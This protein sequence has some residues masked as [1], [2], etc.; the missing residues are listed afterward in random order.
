MMLC[1]L[2][3]LCFGG[4]MAYRLYANHSFVQAYNEEDYETEREEKLLFL[5]FPQGYIPHYNLGNAAYRQ[6]DYNQAVARYNSALAQHPTGDKDCQIRINLALSLCNTIDF[7]SL[8]SQQKV[9]NALFV[10]YKARDVLLENGCATEDGDGH[11]ADAQQLKEDIDRMIEMLKNPDQNNSG[12]DQSNNDPNQ[13]DGS[14]GSG[15]NPSDREKRIQDELEENRKGALEDR[16][17]QQGELD[18]W[19]DY[20]GG[21]GDDDSGGLGSE[22]EV[23]PW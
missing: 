14:G 2:L 11:N 19:S 17:D 9:D 22:K 13:D 21:G 7:Y 12:Q 18:R 16:R 15:G 10:L 3:L 5:N 1:G 20:I 23:N 6:G 8:D 4:F